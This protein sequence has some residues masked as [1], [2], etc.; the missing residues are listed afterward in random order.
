MFKLGADAITFVIATFCGFKDPNISRNYKEICMEKMVNCVIIQ[1]GY[2]T[3]AVV[4]Q[5]REDWIEYAK[6][7]K[8]K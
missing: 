7:N 4:D 3:N 5:C 6:T 1:D 2:S 8:I